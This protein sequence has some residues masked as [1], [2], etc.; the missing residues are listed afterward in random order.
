[1]RIWEKSLGI[2]PKV[3]KSLNTFVLATESIWQES[4]LEV[5]V[6]IRGQSLVMVQNLMHINY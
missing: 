6:G 3:T 4:F 5:P 1:M 2:L